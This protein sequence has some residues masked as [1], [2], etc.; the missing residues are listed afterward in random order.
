MNSKLIFPNSGFPEPAL[1][2]MPL[3]RYAEWI[4]SD[5]LELYRSGKLEAYRE[6]TNQNVDGI[7][8]SFIPDHP[9]CSEA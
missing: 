6:Q 4:F 5:L 2:S 9:V 1:G 8:F 7:P 3:P